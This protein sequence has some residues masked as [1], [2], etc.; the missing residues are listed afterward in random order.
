MVIKRTAQCS[1]HLY[2]AGV[3]WL[4]AFLP[5][6]GAALAQVQPLDAIV[7]VVNDDVIVQSE[8]DDAIAMVLP[9]L[10]AR[11]AEIPSRDVLREQ[12][13][14]R[15]ILERLQTQH[16]EEMGI[17]I[18]EATLNQ[19]LAEIARRNGIPVSQLRETLEAGG[20]S[21]D[22]F[23]EDTRQQLLTA[24]LQQQAVMRD[25]RISKQEVDRFLET[26]RDTLIRRNEVQL[27][28]ILIAVPE[29]ANQAQVA[30]A[31]REITELARRIRAG[32]DFAR[33]AAAHSDGRRAPEGGD[34]GW[35]PIGEVPSLAAE[36]AQTLST[37]EVTDPIRSAS[38][39]HLIQVTDIRGEGPQAVNQTHARHIL[40]RTSEVVSDDEAKQRL[41]QLRLRIVGGADFASL[42]R[43]HSDDTGSALQ[44][45][46]LGWVNPGDTVPAFEET[47]DSLAAGEVSQ[48]FESPFGWHIVQV[49]GRR[50]QD[51]TDELLRLRAKDVLRQRKAEEAT[52]LW[53]QQLREQAYVELR[54]DDL[55][56]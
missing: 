21:F 28:H 3:L 44:G 52:D 30:A 13:L 51:T 38:G 24:R 35:F 42:A 29:D 54:L 48:P 40:I 47:M 37:G 14:E 46:D 39:F 27:G 55:A 5:A 50:D 43:A 1:S 12:V 23:R 16:A 31:R 7:A 56:Q 4:A 25:I 53:L 22:E 26:K 11:G 20:I 9:E 45:G 18:D 8:L 32:E 41:E 10:E 2:V 17:A 36:P 6:S 49:L 34:L 19:A 15:L 33:L